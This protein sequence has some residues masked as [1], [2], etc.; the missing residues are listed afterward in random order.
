MN[1][2][3]EEGTTSRR[4][5]NS[6]QSRNRPNATVE[7]PHSWKV[8]ITIKLQYSTAQA[9]RCAYLEQKLKHSTP[10]TQ[11]EIVENAVQ[12]WLQLN[13]YLNE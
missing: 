2:S 6:R 10:D 12:I 7:M 8:P 13:G 1:E 9:L 4:R 3:S 5:P 11:Q